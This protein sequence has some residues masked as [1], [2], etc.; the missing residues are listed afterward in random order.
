MFVDAAANDYA[1]GNPAFPSGCASGSFGLELFLPQ[2]AVAVD[3][4][5]GSDPNSINPRSKGFIPVA[6]L[7]SAD[8]DVTAV[9]V[10]TLRFG[11]GAAPPVRGGHYENVNSDGFTDLVVHF[12]AGVAGFQ[13]GDT[14]GTLSGETLD[15]TPILGS[16][17][18]RIV[19]CK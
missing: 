16:D 5:P 7:G 6:V 14:V 11:P 19:P 9:V 13:C 18:V 2:I 12:D 1:I 4:K 17:S 10:G 15:G 8:F 3:I